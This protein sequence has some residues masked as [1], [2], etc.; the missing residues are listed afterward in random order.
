MAR[1]QSRQGAGPP[2]GTDTLT[3]E[4]VAAPAHRLLDAVPSQ[5]LAVGHRQVK[6]EGDGEAPK[7]ARA[8]SLCD[9][10]GAS[11]LGPDRERLR[12]G[13]S[14]LGSGEVIAVKMEEVVDLVV[15]GEEPPRL[16]W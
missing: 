2:G 14:V 4:A 15:G 16:A 7:L 1:G 5:D 11:N 3:V 10:L 9:G 8:A 13:G 6:L 12:A